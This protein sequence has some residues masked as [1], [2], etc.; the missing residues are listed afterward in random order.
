[1]SGERTYPKWLIVLGLAVLV[2]GHT[3]VTLRHLALRLAGVRFGEVHAVEAVEGDPN[4]ALVKDPLGVYKPDALKGDY[5]WLGENTYEITANT[6]TEIRVVGTPKEVREDVQGH[7]DYLTGFREKTVLVR[8]ARKVPGI[9][10][11]LA[12]VA[13]GCALAGM[14]WTLLRRKSLPDLRLPIAVWVLLGLCLLSVFDA[15]R[16][17]D[18][19][20]IRADV[21]AGIKEWIQYVEVLGLAWL[22]FHELFRDRRAR[23]WLIWALIGSAAIVILVG[24]IEYIRAVGGYS[25]RGPLDI[26]ELDSTFGFRY[27][28]A[29]SR[30]SGSESS[31]NVL[32]LYL[33][34]VVP[35]LLSLINTP[36]PKWLRVALGGLAALGL[37]LIVNLPLLICAIV[38][39]LVVAAFWP[40]RWALPV[41]LASI[42]VIL[43]LVG[44]V[45][46]HH[47]KILV[48]SMA[49]YRSQ[50]HYGLLPMPMKGRDAAAVGNRWESWQQ[51]YMER[52]AV[53][54]AITWSPLLGHGLGNYQQK[55]N[56]FYGGTRPDLTGHAMMKQPVNFMEKDAHG[57]YWV[58][59]METGGL[60]VAALLWLLAAVLRRLV[61]ARRRRELDGYDRA[62]LL[63]AL[64]AVVCLALACWHG[65]FLARGLQF[66][67]LPFFALPGAVRADQAGRETAE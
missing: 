7:G 12:D 51:K 56:N 46:R 29:R 31:A 47:G 42:V 63:G 18:Q 61:R 65:S 28:P 14:A 38:G 41:T 25:L 36:F 4:A 52:Q 30:T 21:K 66:V 48:D 17:L 44:A 55:I 40:W 8:L 57:L 23:C 32:S 20:G 22:F 45:N 33:A 64:G 49:L 50:D 34:F 37:C 9:G 16:V 26:G 54:T 67:V 10:F 19:S 43:A 39:C 5:L 15:T 11:T 53:L 35:L 62:L 3:Q 58:Q 1:M 27:N 6:A 59:L 13:L 2:L 60:G 24:W